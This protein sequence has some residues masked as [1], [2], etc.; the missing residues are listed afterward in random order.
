M[1]KWIL[2]ITL[3]SVSGPALAQKIRVK[4]V[5]GQQAIIEFSGGSLRPG[6]AYELAQ[7]DFGDSGAEFSSRQY[8]INVGMSLLNT[9]SDAANST[10]DTSFTVVGKFGWN[11]SDFELGPMLSYNS[12]SSGNATVNTIKFGGFGDYN[13]IPNIAGESFIY[14][15]GA[16]GSLGQRDAGNNAKVDLMTMSLGPFAKWFPNGGN[17]GF[18]VDM[19]YLYQNR[20][21]AGAD[22]TISGFGAEVGYIAYF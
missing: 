4:K 11:F 17:Y 12:E 21:G 13:M 9:K 16:Q 15:L 10:N 18:R 6:Q 5:K 22:V 8:V 7:D 3:I 2:F 19:L 14:G 1:K 20:S